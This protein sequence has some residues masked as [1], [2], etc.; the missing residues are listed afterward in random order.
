MFNS[1]NIQYRNQY[2]T[3]LNTNQELRRKN[4]KL[5]KENREL[6]KEIIKNNKDNRNN[7]CYLC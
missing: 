5:N 2:L 3:T 4:K 6:K 7:N 1:Q